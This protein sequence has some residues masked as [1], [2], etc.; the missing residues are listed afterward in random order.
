MFSTIYR[1]TLT[2]QEYKCLITLSKGIL[3]EYERLESQRTT[4]SA[5]A[6]S[7]AVLD[8]T[9]H[10]AL[11]SDSDACEFGVGYDLTFPQTYPDYS[12]NAEP[13]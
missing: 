4:T 10:V 9:S 3:S 8:T 7:T 12:C 2:K 11:V 1:I 6:N 13:G 5:A